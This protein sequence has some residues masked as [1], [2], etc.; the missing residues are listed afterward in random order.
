MSIE[1]VTS[2]CRPTHGTKRKSHWSIDEQENAH[3]RATSSLFLRE[4]INKL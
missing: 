2:P 1:I 3:T 4:M